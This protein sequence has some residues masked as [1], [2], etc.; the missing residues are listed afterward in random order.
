[1]NLKDPPLARLLISGNLNNLL[2][3]ISYYNYRPA[4]ARST[5]TSASHTRGGYQSLEG[6]GVGRILLS[7][8]YSVSSDTRKDT[9]L[10]LTFGI[11]ANA[12]RLTV[13]AIKPLTV[14]LKAL[15]LWIRDNIFSAILYPVSVSGPILSSINAVVYILG[16]VSSLAV[17]DSI[18]PRLVLDVSRLLVFALSYTVLGL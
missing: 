6:L 14:Y 10:L 15:Y 1:M 2:D 18:R 17:L 4:A 5:T 12:S 7:W 9:R 13:L 11:D 3:S 8:N 16:T